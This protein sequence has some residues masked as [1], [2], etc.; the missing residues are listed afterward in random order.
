[1][2]ILTIYTADVTMY[3]IKLIR[4]Q[5]DFFM[6]KIR[7]KLLLVILGVFVITPLTVN[8]FLS[9]NS[10][11]KVSV[12]L[13][14]NDPNHEYIS[15]LE[16]KKLLDNDEVKENQKKVDKKLADAWEDIKNTNKFDLASYDLLSF[17]DIANGDMTK[18]SSSFS[19]KDFSNDFY[20]FLGEV[21]LSMNTGD[22]EPKVLIKKDTSE[23]IFA[24]KDSDG[25]NIVKTFKRNN[26]K[27]DRSE[28]KVKGKPVL[29]IDK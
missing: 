21:Q 1:M 13:T 20:G 16:A 8:S 11:R 25:N 17:S 28:K 4:G 19:N 5:G 29:V 7:L 14:D 24:Y 15:D 12:S 2:N 6:K 26:D 27:I 23:V 22:L 9:I 18:K 10:N 3:L